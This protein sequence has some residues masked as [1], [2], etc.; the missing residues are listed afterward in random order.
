MRKR[1]I[2]KELIKYKLKNFIYITV[3]AGLI[4][5]S[6]GILG[7][8]NPTGVKALMSIEQIKII[9]PERTID[10]NSA[11][12]IITAETQNTEGSSEP[13][14]GTTNFTINSSSNTGLFSPNGV[15]WWTSGGQVTLTAGQSDINFYYKDSN[16][17]THTITVDAVDQDW[18]CDQQNIIVNDITD[19]QTA[20][21][22]APADGTYYNASTMP[23]N[24]S[25]KAADDLGGLGLNANS[26]EFYI[27]RSSDNHYW[28]RTNWDS[29]TVQWLET[30]HLETTD[31]SETDWTSSTTLPT[32]ADG[33]YKSAAKAI[34][35]NGHT[36]TGSEIT[37]YFDKTIPTG[38]ITI[39][40]NKGVTDSDKVTLTLNTSEQYKMQVYNYGD[41]PNTWETFSATKLN[42]QLTPNLGTKKVCVKFKDQAENISNE[43]CDEIDYNDV[44]KNI[45]KY[46]VYATNPTPDQAQIISQKNI[47][48]TMQNT[49]TK[50][51]KDTSITIAEYS[52]NPGT[53]LD[54][55]FL[56]KYF[57]ISAENQA[58]INFPVSVR[59]YFTQ[60][61]LDNAGITDVSNQLKGL[62]YFDSASS[63]WKLYDETGVTLD[64]TA[65]SGFIGFVWAK[66]SHFTPMVLGADIT[67]P[68]KP[69]NLNAEAKDKEVKLS[70]DQVSDAQGYYVRYREAT[71]NDTNKT[72]TEVY[73]TNHDAT[74]GNLTNNTLYEFGVRAVDSAG[75]KGEWAI[76]VQTPIAK[77]TAVSSNQGTYGYF[78][79]T[80]YAAEDQ[81][82]TPSD[83]T[84]QTADNQSEI[85]NTTPLD[86]NQGETQSARTAVIL[87]IIII[88]IGAALGGY[89]GYQWWLGEG[90]VAKTPTPPATVE[91][92]NGIKVQTRKK[93]NRR[94]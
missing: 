86:E 52:I 16:A 23:A 4:M 50:N 71:S 77:A 25:G 13:V 66:V 3:M 53:N 69:A 64:S 10:Q 65:K 47:E 90:E 29:T 30:T 43:Y 84:S 72:Y 7:F 21:I 22:T 6:A 89:Y 83:S 94:W 45:T 82:Q 12:L 26:T 31:G 37:F 78:I 93:S 51:G 74:I 2:M 67:A 42:W 9:T 24:F 87:G 73:T 41:T 91:K 18:T 20:S 14:A 60:G 57:D 75:N 35:K 44:A 55:A 80:A 15:D 58:D 40:D 49:A 92:K 79:G 85:T 1:R 27:Q 39:N 5:Q 36:F 8:W 38:S 88:A 17:G 70:W 54:L 63:K 28:D 19:P 34:D 56:G 11:S 48:I 81:S 62:Y 32:W 33:T 76:V 59:I 61:D 68:V 46:E